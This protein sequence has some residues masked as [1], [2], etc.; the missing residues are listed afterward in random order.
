[1]GTKTPFIATLSARPRDLHLLW[2]EYEFGIGGR[3]PA[4]KFTAIKRGQVKFKYFRRKAVW[5]TINHMVRAGFTAQVAIDKIYK[6]AQVP[7]DKICEGYGQ[8]TLTQIINRMRRDK[9]G[10]G[11]PELR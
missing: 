7:I 1:M 6:G 5:D 11:H 3:K 9:I 4:R 2:L 10:G 8:L